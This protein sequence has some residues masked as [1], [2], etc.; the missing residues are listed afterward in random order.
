[1]YDMTVGMEQCI[2][3]MVLKMQQI[4]ASWDEIE[5]VAR[6]FSSAIR[7]SAPKSTGALAATASII[8][9]DAPQGSVTPVSIGVG[10]FSK[11]GYPSDKAPSG[12]IE[13]FVRDNPSKRGGRPPAARAAWWYLSAAGKQTLA[14]ERVAGRYGSFGGKPRYWQAVAEGTVPSKSGADLP[15]NDY[16]VH[17]YSAISGFASHIDAKMG[18]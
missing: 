7:G 4:D 2:P 16:I 17:A 11:L 15:A 8:E 10:P 13:R 6:R 3:A 12:I 9:W 5:N 18:S 1:M 14:A